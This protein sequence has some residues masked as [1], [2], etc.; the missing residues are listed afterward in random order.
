M[1]DIIFHESGKIQ[2]VGWF[3]ATQTDK[4]R[5]AFEPVVDSCVIDMKDLEY[6][7]SAGLG[8]LLVTAQRV[9]RNGGQ[10]TLRN[11]NPNIRRILAISGMDR[12]FK[13]EE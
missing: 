7:S 10:V 13:I 8:I 3:D 9:D 5:S 11:V 1:L 12:I 6:M 2:L 4:A